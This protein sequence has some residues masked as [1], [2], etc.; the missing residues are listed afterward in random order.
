M[1]LRYDELVNCMVQATLLPEPTCSY[2]DTWACMSN[3]TL[4]NLRELRL[5]FVPVTLTQL[6][7]RLCGS[8]AS[9]GPGAVLHQLQVLDLLDCGGAV[10]PALAMQPPAGGLAQLQSLQLHIVLAEEGDMDARLGLLRDLPS[11]RELSLQ[12]LMAPQLPDAV[13]DCTLLTRLDLS[14]SCWLLELPQQI[15]RLSGLQARM[16]APNG[17]RHG[18]GCI[19]LLLELYAVL[20][21]TCMP[22][23]A[24]A[25]YLTN[26]PTFPTPP[27]S[28][29]PC[30]HALTT[31]VAFDATA[32]SAAAL[33]LPLCL[34]LFI[35]TGVEPRGLW[36]AAQHHGY[37]QP[38]AAEQPQSVRHSQ[39]VA[40]T[41]HVTQQL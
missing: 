36:L 7:A 30:T 28:L 31:T 6:A 40:Q 5:G 25:Q 14:Y 18:F 23:P 26:H 9:G 34:L 27:P 13:M 16:H 11:L 1:P 10:L 33:H 19:P 22:P 21:C 8:S 39:N 15:S 4:S 29:P 35:D 3:A 37:I 24:G 32:M 12:R 17:G 20:L 38:D 2:N 41:R